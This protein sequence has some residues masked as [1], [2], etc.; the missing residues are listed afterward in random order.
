MH[1]LRHL[2]LL[3]LCAAA[4]FSAQ[5]APV[6]VPAMKTG[7]QSY[8]FFYTNTT[9]LLKKNINPDTFKQSVNSQLPPGV[10]A[11][12]TSADLNATDIRCGEVTTGQ[13]QLGYTEL[14]TYLNEILLP[15]DP[16]VIGKDA[17]IKQVFISNSISPGGGLVADTVGRVSHV[18]FTVRAAQFGMLVDPNSA[19]SIQFIVNGQALPPQPLTAGVPL[20]VA[21][22]DPH[23]F[24]D[25]TIIAGGFLGQAWVADRMGFLPL[26]QY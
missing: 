11:C 21:V 1:K 18:H 24:N 8:A 20:Y 4:S 17:N 15:K 13:M 6:M 10:R 22:E 25:V 19:T 3:P 5:A 14:Y 2:L 23:G 26:A 9:A 7:A 12:W 16:I